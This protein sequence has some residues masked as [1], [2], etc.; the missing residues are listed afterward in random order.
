M[1][2][3]QP[4]AGTRTD[5][6]T[7]FCGWIDFRDPVADRD[8]TVDRM[9]R[10]TAQRPDMA[11][12]TVLAPDGA[13][14]WCRTPTTGGSGSGRLPGA[15]DAAAVC[16]LHT[17]RI[18]N[19]GDLVAELTARGVRLAA[20]TTAELLEEA[21]RLWGLGL[22]ERL[23][24]MYAIAIWDGETR[25]LHLIRDRIGMKPLYYAA[26]AGGLGFA[27]KPAGIY[28]HPAFAPKVDRSSLTVLLTPRHALPGETPLAGLREVPA[29]HVVSF[30]R[31]GVNERAYWQLASSPHRDGFDRTAEQVR[32]L[33]A[34]IVA[35]QL[36]DGDVSSC[37]ATMLS[38]GL[39][40]TTVAALSAAGLESE[41][42]DRVLETFCLEFA[43]DTAE[44][45]VGTDL[46]PE[47][48][49]PFAAQAAA[50]LGTRH[51]RLSI[52]PEQ[53]VAALPATR[54][55]RDLPGWGQFDASTYL[56]FQ[57]MGARCPIA[58]TGEIADELFGGYP[59]FFDPKLIAR[60]HFPWLE[61]G[62]QLDAYLSQDVRARFDPAAEKY[63]RYRTWLDKV[64]RLEGEAA[65]DARMREVFF[66][67]NTG[68]LAVLLDRMDRMAAAAGLEMR[69]PFCDH[70]LQQYLWNVP[71]QLKCRNGIKGL[72][73][74]A[75][76]DIVPAV[77]LNRKKSAYPHVQ[78]SAYDEALAAEALAI[79][80]D[81]TARVRQLFDAQALRSFVHDLRAGR[82]GLNDAHMLIHFI[83]LHH[84]LEDYGIA[85]D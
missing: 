38:G 29:A 51:H 45:Y 50:E 7:G 69:F 81:R 46:R 70:R 75:V 44:T 22:A 62:P 63:A 72:L 59:Y 15:R 32:G 66:L 85:L 31:A 19:Q 82:G 71:W 54:A 60:D 20:G 61:T 28:A 43:S 1:L 80:D 30:S 83:E 68:R 41:G 42:Q 53:L 57:T 6:L 67:S 9:A 3:A 27:T 79:L 11:V 26:W 2:L 24:G 33:L 4:T 76:A 49:A 8:A 84:W 58:L 25:T 17:G 23:R 52:S 34:E 21:Y 65:D 74:A 47:R 37:V 39:D 10:A 13:F 18:Y 78:S 77:T 14:G 56:L 16:V 35:E 73:K 48:D 40:S 64:P 5:T 55:A 12:D 36:P